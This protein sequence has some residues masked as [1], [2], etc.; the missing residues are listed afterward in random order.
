[1]YKIAKTYE[2]SSRLAALVFVAIG[3]YW[4]VVKTAEVV[5]TLKSSRKRD[6]THFRHVHSRRSSC[7]VFNVGRVISML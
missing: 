1:M 7:T 6:D 2:T 4:G 3:I 5:G